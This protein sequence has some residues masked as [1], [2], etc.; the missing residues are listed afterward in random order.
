MVNL[1][2]QQIIGIVSLALILTGVVV[3]ENMKESYYCAAEDNV[4]ECVRLSS[5]GLTCYYLTA[6][7]VTK[8]DRCTGGV[9]ESLDSHM[10]SDNRTGND[11]GTVKVSANGKEWIC[12]AVDG[13]V[14]PYTRCSSGAYEGYLGELVH[15]K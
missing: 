7:D 8:G 5:S 15:Q 13:F 9:W 10:G 14:D 4:K 11:I 2:T 1:S 6:P 12:Q 3:V